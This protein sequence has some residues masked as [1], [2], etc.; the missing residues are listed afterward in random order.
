LYH[1]PAKYLLVIG[2]RICL[3]IPD[4]AGSM[5]VWYVRFFEVYSSAIDARIRA[6]LVLDVLSLVLFAVLDIEEGV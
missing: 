2:D 5:S 4:K 6:R 3:A 1:S